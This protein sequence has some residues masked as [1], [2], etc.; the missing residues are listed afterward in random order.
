MDS[1]ALG[2]HIKGTHKMKE[3]E[4]K[5]KY[6]VYKK[7]PNNEVIDRKSTLKRKPSEQAQEELARPQKKLKG[8]NFSIEDSVGVSMDLERDRSNLLSKDSRRLEKQNGLTGEEGIKTVGSDQ[9]RRNNPKKR[10]QEQMVDDQRGSE[11]TRRRSESETKRKSK[12]SSRRIVSVSNN[13]EASLNEYAVPES[14]I[15]QTVIETV[16]GEVSENSEMETSFTKQVELITNKRIGVLKK[17]SRFFNEPVLG[18]RGVQ[19]LGEKRKS[20][21]SF[22]KEGAGLRK[23]AKE[24]F[25]PFVDVEY[26]CNLKDCQDC[27]KV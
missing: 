11:G 27:G 22:T 14:V 3:K 6:C 19:M 18:N 4:Y 12:E 10:I 17:E 13:I 26:D 25:D 15:P 9:K 23:K 21:S 24:G 20:Q 1:D 16:D 7:K 8:A 2:G 5:E